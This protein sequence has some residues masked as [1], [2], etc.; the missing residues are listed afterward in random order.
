MTSIYQ[1]N[2]SIVYIRVPIPS[3]TTGSNYFDPLELHLTAKT[4]IHPRT[5]LS[6]NEIKSVSHR[7]VDTQSSFDP[8]SM[9]PTIPL[10]TGTF[11]Y[12]GSMFAL[13]LNLG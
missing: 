10:L 8:K 2:P 9:T 6:I 5:N 1:T 11:M 3:S 4:C 7:E 12:D 13:C